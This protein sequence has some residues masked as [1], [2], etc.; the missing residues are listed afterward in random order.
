MNLDSRVVKMKH[1]LRSKLVISA[2]T[3]DHDIFMQFHHWYDTMNLRL[4]EQYAQG[5]LKGTEVPRVTDMCANAYGNFMC[6]NVFPNCTYMPYA[7]WPYER[8]YEVINTCKEVCLEV[9]KW[10][11]DDWI[12]HEM[13]CDDLISNKI[14]LAIDPTMMTMSPYDRREAGGHAC[15][16]VHLST[17]FEGGVAGVAP[18]TTM[19]MGLALLALGVTR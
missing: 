4:L 14:D 1:Y 19:I 12:Q 16:T 9:K 2:L 17:R 18:R 10:C 6:S 13:R 7:K 3:A 15:A 8:Q 5:F 11:E